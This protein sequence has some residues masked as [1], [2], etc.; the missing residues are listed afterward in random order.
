[1]LN[2]KN[3]EYINL[4]IQNK[5]ILME[6]LKKLGICK[7]KK[8]LIM[9]LM[10]IGAVFLGAL[11]AKAQMAMPN[12][13]IN[14]KNAGSPQEFSKGLQILIWLTILT[15]APSIFIMTTAF[16]RIVIVLSLTR[17]AIGT[18]Q[19]PPTQVIVG[20]AMMLT[21]FVMA[22]TISEINEKA[23]Q[24]YMKSEITQEAALKRGLEP[25][26]QFMFRQTAESDLALFV[27]LSKIDKPANM[28]DIPTFV[29]MP[30]FVISELKTAF[31]I[32]FMIFIPFLVIDIVISSI[33]VSMG[34]LF[35]PPVMISMPFKIILFVLVDGWHL[36]AKALV[37]G[38]S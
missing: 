18:G 35:L 34:M 7:S 31:E 24:P 19:L 29:L 9:I 16:T 22:P 1:M 15:L 37:M 17:Q 10:A 27:K 8:F 23:L 5:L 25:I 12:I 14:F 26:R 20:L 38:F 6:E 21:F 3:D 11:S 32:G 30:A 28:G 33:L 36:I 2:L 4:K 13:D